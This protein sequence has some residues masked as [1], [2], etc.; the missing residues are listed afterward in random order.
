V[1]PSDVKGGTYAIEFSFGSEYFSSAPQ[2][3]KIDG[4]AVTAGMITTV[5]YKVRRIYQ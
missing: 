1:L 3:G 4:V 2:G 5:D